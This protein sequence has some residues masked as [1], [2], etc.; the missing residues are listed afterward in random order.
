[1][2]IAGSPSLVMPLNLAELAYLKH[3]SSAFLFSLRFCDRN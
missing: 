3:V 1:M 2:G